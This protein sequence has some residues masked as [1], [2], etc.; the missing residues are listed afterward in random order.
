MPEDSINNLLLIQVLDL[1]QFFEKA[2]RRLGR[3]FS[4]QNF[5]CQGLFQLMTNRLFPG[6]QF[7]GL[8]CFFDS[9]IATVVLASSFRFWLPSHHVLS[10]TVLYRYISLYSCGFWRSDI[11]DVNAFLLFNFNLFHIGFRQDLTRHLD[12]QNTFF[13]RCFNIILVSVFRQGKNALE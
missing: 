13:K 4:R 5:S 9:E 7:K 8:Q 2:V 6:G 3:P 1:L 11:I 10:D 12:G